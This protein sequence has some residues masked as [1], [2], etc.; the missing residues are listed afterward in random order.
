MTRGVDHQALTEGLAVGP[1]R[2]AAGAQHEAGEARI[3]E[4]AGDAHEVVAA[5]REGDR[6]RL[7][8]VDGVVGREH[9]AIGGR[10]GEITL[11][12]A[13]DQFGAGIGVERADVAVTGENRNHGRTIA[14]GTR[15]G[16]SSA[17]TGRRIRGT[18]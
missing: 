6:V 18:K 14:L 15:H 11:E 8:L 10:Q 9:R 4:Q 7:D 1:R 16:A 13:G 17:K 12:P 5:P 3:L 2:A